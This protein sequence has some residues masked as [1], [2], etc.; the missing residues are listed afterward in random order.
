MLL[1]IFGGF[2]AVPVQAQDY[3]LV[4]LNGRVMDPETQLD[5]V[6]NV[7]IKDG[8]IA[9]ITKEKITG[10]KTIDATGHIVAP[11]F[12]DI[13]AHGQNIGDYR[14]QAMQG[15][16]TMLELESGVLPIA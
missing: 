3:D 2:A 13:H 5:A 14:M 6:R 15:V 10:Q 16:T 1:A 11:G 8:T 9:L 4:I 12:I 7:G